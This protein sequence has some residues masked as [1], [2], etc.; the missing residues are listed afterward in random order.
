LSGCDTRH[1]PF[2]VI[3]LG[4]MVV[5]TLVNLL[6]VGAFGEAEYWFASIKVFAQ[7]VDG[8]CSKLGR[9]SRFRQALG[10]VCL[11]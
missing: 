10:P 11:L 7:F 2:W 8:P 6:S 9:R 1:I 3:A 5:M 4:L